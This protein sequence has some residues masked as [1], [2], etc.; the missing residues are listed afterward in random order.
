M[1]VMLCTTSRDV[2]KRSMLAV[3]LLTSAG[4]CIISRSVQNAQGTRFEQDLERG[5]SNV[6]VC[7]CIQLTH[8]LSPTSPPLSL[9]HTCTQSSRVHRLSLV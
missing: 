4:L 3:K 8:A 5:V 7:F 6:S 9:G 1:P 2:Q